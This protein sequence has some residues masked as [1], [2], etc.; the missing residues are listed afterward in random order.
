M[1]IWK[2]LLGILGVATLY[3][4]F[5]V[6]CSLFVNPNKEY[7][8]HSAFYRHLL[9]TVTAIGLKIMRVR[10]HATGIEKIPV[11]TRRIL[12]V[13]N[14]QSNFDPIVTWHILKPWQI[15]FISKADN[16]KIPIFGRF[17]RKCCF[18][19]I[20]RENPRN[21][22][23]TVNKAAGLLTKGEVSVGVYPEG[24]RSKSGEL[25]PFHN[26]VFKIAQKANA[27]IVV[28]SVIGTRDI[29]KNYPLHHTDVYLDVLEVIPPDA[30]AHT[31][32]DA[33]GNRIR[34]L[35]EQRLRKADGSHERPGGALATK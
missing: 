21:A 16:F 34:N 3:I 15:A 12:F 33:L 29:H 32:R 7:E 23:K 18:M 6:V 24:T 8:T 11:G 10:V 25:L 13:G 4:L 27:P 22:L 17:I 19:A 31:K 2:I 35:L 30:V 20:D 28:L 1:L 14:H 5:L 9:N 26:G